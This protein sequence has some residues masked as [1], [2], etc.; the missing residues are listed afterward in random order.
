[1]YIADAKRLTHAG[2]RKMTTAIERPRGRRCDLLL[3]RT[4]GT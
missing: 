2:A 4:R 3:S 1:M